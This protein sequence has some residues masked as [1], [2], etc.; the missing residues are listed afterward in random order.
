MSGDNISYFDSILIEYIQEEIKKIL[1]NKSISTNT[2]RI[3]A[4]DSIKCGNFCLDLIAFM[5]NSR[6]LLDYTNLVSPNEY[7]KSNKMILKC[8]E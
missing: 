8:F 2:Y 6:I 3:Q 5:M 1:G 7:E 4:Y